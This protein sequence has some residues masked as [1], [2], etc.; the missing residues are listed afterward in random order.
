MSKYG[1]SLAY[2]T[3][4]STSLIHVSQSGTEKEVSRVITQKL[5]WAAGILKTEEQRLVAKSETEDL[6][7]ITEWL[8]SVARHDSFNQTGQSNIPRS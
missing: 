7:F 8:N 6:S 3:C 5:F 1:S 4:V 2:R